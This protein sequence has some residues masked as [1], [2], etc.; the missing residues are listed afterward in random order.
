MRDYG[1]DPNLSLDRA[2]TDLF[3]TPVTSHEAHPSM[4]QTV[5]SEH[6]YVVP[7]FRANPV[8]LITCH[9]NL[10][11]VVYKDYV[12]IFSLKDSTGWHLA[13]LSPF[14]SAPI[15]RIALSSKITTTLPIVN[16]VNSTNTAAI[17]TNYL[18]AQSGL[19]QLLQQQQSIH[20]QNQSSNQ[21]SLL[22]TSALQINPSPVTVA[23]TIQSQSGLPSSVAP[24][25]VSL[26]STSTCMLAASV[27]STI[28]VWCLYPPA[29]SNSSAIAACGGAFGV[30][31]SSATYRL[32]PLTSFTPTTAMGKPGYHGFLP[33]AKDP[34]ASELVGRYDLNHRAVDYIMFIDAHLVA[35][36]RRGLVGVRH[37]MTNTWQVWSTVPILSY[38]VAASELLLLGCANGRICSINIQKFPLR[39]VD[40]DLLVTEMYRD[41]LQDPITALSVH[42][43]K[44]GMHCTSIC[45]FSSPY[46]LKSIVSAA[47]SQRLSNLRLTAVHF[48]SLRHS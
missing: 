38:G 23:N 26:A 39:I 37:M 11:A 44:T 45:R 17:G 15:D 9:Q 48:I 19:F 27:G 6:A 14:L 18:A 24:A 33:R 36:S 7:A 34:W 3:A 20:L 41:P 2:S 40:N 13:W 8:T 28:F 43:T 1:P 32:S 42:L 35:L 22:P 31:T 5:D 16:A 21:A 4:T 12:G 30:S 25:T 29:S 46:I 10:M 47:L